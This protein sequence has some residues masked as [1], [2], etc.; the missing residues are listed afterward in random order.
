MEVTVYGT[1]TCGVCKQV[2]AFLK[3]QEVKHEYKTVGEDIAVDELEALIG[4]APRTV[5][6]I[7]ID[8]VET[9]F[10]ILKE[11]V[12]TSKNLGSLEL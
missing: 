1:N 5:P 7:L 12:E 9:G 2:V 3:S 4:R 8:G 11:R 6:I 10:D